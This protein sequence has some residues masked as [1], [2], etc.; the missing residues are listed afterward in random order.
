MFLDSVASLEYF[1]WTSFKT[2]SGNASIIRGIMGFMEISLSDCNAVTKLFDEWNDIFFKISIFSMIHQFVC[3]ILSFKSYYT[4]ITN[5]ITCEIIYYC[6]KLKHKEIKYIINIQKQYEIS[7]IL[8]SHLYKKKR[9]NSSP[10][11]YLSTI[12]STINPFLSIKLPIRYT[13]MNN[14]ILIKVSPYHKSSLSSRFTSI[15]IEGTMQIYK[16]VNRSEGIG[17]NQ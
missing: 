11:L 14:P 6:Y 1:K 7:S 12:N 8:Y 16:R 3:S 10:N 13:C 15:R 2:S 17:C 5:H 4:H 9:R